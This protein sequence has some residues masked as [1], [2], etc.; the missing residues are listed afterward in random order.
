M[1]INPKYRL[2]T[3]SGKSIIMSENSLSFDGIPT[4]NKTAEFIWKKL[5]TG[6]EAE[7]VVRSLAAECN[8]SEDE[9][10]EEVIDFISLLKKAGIIE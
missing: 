6:A 5:E 9:I 7:D 8:V 2:R 4:L 3:V 10:R 1:K